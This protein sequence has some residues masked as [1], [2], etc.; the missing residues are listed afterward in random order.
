[1][2]RIKDVKYSAFP[3]CLLDLYLPEQGEFPVL[4]YFHNAR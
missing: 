3:E 2:K 4:V 1:M